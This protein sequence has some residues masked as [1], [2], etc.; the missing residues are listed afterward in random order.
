MALEPTKRSF[1]VEPRKSKLQDIDSVNRAQKLRVIVWALPIGGG[2]GAVLG[3]SLGH[4]FLGLL[5]GP[6]LVYSVAMGVANSAGKG[7]G[8]IYMPSGSST[9]RRKEYSRAKSLEVRGEFAGAVR[10]YEVAILEDPRG[11]EPYLNIARLYRD[12]L[13]ELDLSVQWFRRA[14]REANLSAGEAVRTHRELAE[15]FLHTLREPRK[16]A[17][18][19]ARLAESFPDTQDGKWAARELAEIKEGL[20][21]ER[22]E[23]GPEPSTSSEEDP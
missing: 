14:Q 3:A 21:R 8:V 17:P 7:A 12:Q 9:P 23:D 5:L 19:L 15:I 13:K 20:V 22:E 6:L 1:S 18:E 2:L 10:A 11:A 4:P 16:A